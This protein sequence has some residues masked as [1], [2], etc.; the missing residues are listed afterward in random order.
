M[1]RRLSELGEIRWVEAAFSLAMTP[2]SSGPVLVGVDFE[3]S[4]AL[5]SRLTRASEDAFERGLAWARASG[6][7]IVVAHVYLPTDDQGSAKPHTAQSAELGGIQR[8]LDGLRDRAQAVGT[9]ASVRVLWGDLVDELSRLIDELVAERAILGCSK[10][11]A[12]AVRA[13]LV[14]GTPIEFGRN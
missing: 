6:T 14:G 1:N 2:S 9:D 12:D 7:S 13:R 10:P 4:G 3:R 11:V 8:A 5:E